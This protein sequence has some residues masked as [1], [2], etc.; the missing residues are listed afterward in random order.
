MATNN[1]LNQPTPDYRR[2]V[3]NQVLTDNQLNAVLDYLNH[4]DRLSRLLL[5]GVGIV[6]GLDISY[7]QPGR[8][9][10]LS[11]GVAVTTAGDLLNS[12][13][14]VFTGFKQF[15]D[16][17]V[18]YPFFLKDE[19]E[20]MSLWALAEDVS[21]SDVHPL[22]QFQTK[23]DLKLRDAVAVLY[24]E[25]YLDEEK[26]CSAVDC[27]TQGQPVVNRLR[28][29][30]VS[31]DDAQKIAERDSL[32][33]GFIQHGK[34]NGYQI[35][36][37]HYAPRIV[38]NRARTQTFSDFKKRYELSFESLAEKI[39]ALT[40]FGIFKDVFNRISIDP[41]G[42]L[43]EVSPEKYSFQY[44][45]GFY[46]DLTTAYN[47]LQ[48]A[49]EKRIGMCSPDPEAFP[50][51]VLLGEIAENQKVVRHSFYPSAAHGNPML[52]DVIQSFERILLMIKN[53][54]AGR[55]NE[56][57][58]TP[59]KSDHYPLGRRAV[60]FYYNL[61]K[62]DSTASFLKRWAGNSRDLTLN[63]YGVNYPD[64][65]F[66]PLEV[67][68]DGHDFYRVEGHAG[69]N[70]RDAQKKIQSVRDGNGLPFDI[71]PVAV[72][73]Y[74]DETLVDFDQY[75]V[76]FEDLQVV[77]E[78]WNE[79]QQCLIRS[80]SAFLSGFSV[81]EPG[82]HTAY[83]PVNTQPNNN[84]N[85][86]NNA[87]DGGFIGTV[88]EPVF[89]PVYFPGITAY[90]P[91]RQ[92]YGAK[93]VSEKQSIKSFSKINESTGFVL[94]DKIKPS[95]SKN[96]ITVKFLDLMP[97]GVINWQSDIREATITIPA[98]IIGHL[99]E[100]EDYKLTDIGEFSDDNLNSF[101][102][103]LHDLSNRASSAINRLQH[104][105]A[106][107][108]SEIKDKIWLS[109]YLHLLN[110]IAASR[111]LI[112]KIKVLYE[113]IIERKTELFSELTLQHFIDKHPG[114]EHKAGVE[115]GG[116]LVLLYYSKHTGP[117]SRQQVSWRQ[118]QL[119][120]GTGKESE[121]KLFGEFTG[122]ERDHTEAILGRERFHQ[123]GVF[124]EEIPEGFINVNV[125]DR[126]RKPLPD[127]PQHGDVIGDLCLPYVC[128]SDTPSV[129]FVFP[130]QLAT[131]RI[132]VDHVCVD[133]NGKA[134]P[135]QL[136]VL[137]ESGTIKAFAGQAELS[138]AIMERDNGIFFNPEKV[139]SEQYGEL[140][141]FEINGQPVDPTL[142]VVRKP[143]ARFEISD[144]VTFER[145]NSGAVLLIK[146]IS[147]P[148]DELQFEWNIDG[149]S[150][151][152]ENATEFKHTI[153]VRP[154]QN[155]KVEVELTAFNKYCSDTHRDAIEFKV[156][157]G[158]EPDNPN[159]PDEPI[160]P[161]DRDRVDLI[162]RTVGDRKIQVIKVVR[163][164]TGIRLKDAKELVDS[165][166][167]V[168]MRSITVQEARKFAK[169]F[170]RVGATVQIK[171]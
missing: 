62:A 95:D 75:R 121:L 3:D 73:R 138:D 32:L 11:K 57:K 34:A 80:A 126:F 113:T 108:E 8:K 107:D 123:P 125:G 37:P 165:A 96:D 144:N 12:A 63:Y 53:F 103:A 127:E 52:E 39:E 136:T 78:A 98:Q 160:N 69:K 155:M 134:D 77:L 58:I 45:Y 148:F 33:S 15:D 90:Q 55:K 124:L 146:N 130:D 145:N 71:K 88:F 10:R 128:C 46:K 143:S 50:K 48:V 7:D 65:N 72:G 112:E 99:K 101:L 85:G 94:A 156:P 81:K 76:F 119:L 104:L 22:S 18:K 93:K 86:G 28:V 106:K 116:T 150:V 122:E 164:I 118:L 162:L 17:N 83:K 5:H 82:T 152:N 133:E 91:K 14:K 132:P 153:K 111:C 30:L 27:D 16:A 120:G 74:P 140:I 6:C 43:L 26:D 41:A 131:L 135:V 79:E 36:A 110:R 109:D 21:P 149:R 47:E 67:V 59:S 70:V 159:E 102:K 163:E 60:P 56:I 2:F 54:D 4:Q 31:A 161:N 157:G 115:R 87:G 23:T 24:L 129:T 64:E 142:H 20:T 147:V 51:H 168:V 38:L 105:I 171:K 1:L 92:K 158:N 66:D 141:R 29:L 170:E 49:L 166:P 97:T 13:E 44:C 89:T 68:L 117:S 169:Q 40:E 25:D 61:E 100:V 151:A 35:P 154:G 42:E 9:V 84:N 19:A 137:P 167:S 139:K 114:A